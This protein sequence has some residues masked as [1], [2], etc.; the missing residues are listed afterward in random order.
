MKQKIRMYGPY[1]SVFTLITIA[2]QRLELKDALDFTRDMM[3][4]GFDDA[5]KLFE[6][7]FGDVYELCLTEK[8]FLEKE[9]EVVRLGCDDWVLD[10]AIKKELEEINHSETSDTPHSNSLSNE[11]Q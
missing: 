5:I 11:V 6:N 8:D 4:V 1:R 9:G 7:K 2:K 3:L 10:P